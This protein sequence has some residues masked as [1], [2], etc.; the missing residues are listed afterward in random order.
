MKITDVEAIQINPK[1]CARNSGQKPRFA[2]IDTQTIFKVTCDNGI[3]GW[4]DTRGHVAMDQAQIDGMVGR[5]PVDFLMASINTGLSGA[6]YDAVGKH[7]D[8][9]AYKLIGEKVRDRVPVAAWTRPASPEDLAAEVQRAAAEGYMFF[10][11]HSCTY[12]CVVEQT[13]A[14]QDVAPEGFKFHWDFNHNRTSSSIMR[15]VAEIEKYP[16]VGVLEDPLNWRDLEGWHRLRE[17]TSLPLLMHVPQLGGGPE[18]MK[19]CADLYMI[20]EHGIANSIRRGWAAAEANASCV[21]QLTGG[22]L[23]KAMAMHLG[24]ALPNISHSTN[25]DDQYDED[26][27]GGRLE[28]AEGSTPV[29]EG[30]GLGVDVDEQELQRIRQNPKT[31]VPRVISEL[32]MPQGGRFALQGWPSVDRLTGFPEGNVRGIN[33]HLWEEDGTPE[34]TKRWDELAD[35]P[36]LE[37][38]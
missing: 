25:L 19:G 16:V 4:G 12:Y 37:K 6:I 30:A 24:A 9:P 27:T 15:L 17:K 21:I 31:I 33:L 18:I 34:W 28:V 10:K 13:Q 35:G 2:G 14:V 29:P 32:H 38:Y 5:N 23:S 36:R 20:A 7:L 26:V 11:M 3:V 22:T 8:V 1:L